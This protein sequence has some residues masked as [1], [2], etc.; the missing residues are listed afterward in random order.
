MDQWVCVCVLKIGRGSRASRDKG[1]SASQGWPGQGHLI[2]RGCQGAQAGA[3][4]KSTAKGGNH[5]PVC[6]TST[7]LCLAN[8]FLSLL[9][10]GFL[11]AISMRSIGSFR[12][13]TIH[14]V[15]NPSIV[16]PFTPP[17]PLCCF[18]SPL[19]LIS[20][21]FLQGSATCSSF[22]LFG[23]DCGPS[24]CL[25]SPSATPQPTTPI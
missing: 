9:F 2:V 1:Q 11:L 24:F 8:L 12:S 13:K 10:F 7:I 19:L 21:S 5:Q 18:Q 3:G 25:L 6:G 15:Y 14:R 4:S 22:R 23:G 17:F 16:F 20:A